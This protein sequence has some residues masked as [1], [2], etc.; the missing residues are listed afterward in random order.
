MKLLYCWDF[1]DIVAPLYQRWKG[2][3]CLVEVPQKGELR[4]RDPIGR[5]TTWRHPAN[6][7]PFVIGARQRTSCP[8]SA[9]TDRAVGIE[10]NSP[11]ARDSQG[12]LLF[13]PNRL[14]SFLHE[15]WNLSCPTWRHYI[16]R[17]IIGGTS[18]LSTKLR[19]ST[20]PLGRDW[21]S[22]YLW[23]VASFRCGA[24]AKELQSIPAMAVVHSTCLEGLADPIG[25]DL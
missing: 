23:E 18:L 20:R 10:V 15:N 16:S 14:G 1:G 2:R 6:P 22:D 7:R 9:S 17:L 12:A 8:G 24:V 3:T 4:L 19:S 13:F 21:A 25:K 5:T 11:T